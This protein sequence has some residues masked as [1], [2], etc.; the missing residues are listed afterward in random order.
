MNRVHRAIDTL[1]VYKTIARILGEDHRALKAR[2]TQKYPGD[3][4][5]IQC[6]LIDDEVNQCAKEVTGRWIEKLERVDIW[7]VSQCRTEMVY[8]EWDVGSR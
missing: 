7:A 4:W 6:V 1:D 8:S 3:G 5:A 2:A